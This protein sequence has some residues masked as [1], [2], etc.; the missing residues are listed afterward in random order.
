MET[1]LT[2]T[3][4]IGILIIIVSVI[5]ITTIVIKQEVRNEKIYTLLTLKL[6]KELAKMSQESLEKEFKKHE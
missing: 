5:K 4:I 1:I 2:T 3:L 6:T